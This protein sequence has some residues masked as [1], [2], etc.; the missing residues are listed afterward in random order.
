VEVAGGIG[1]DIVVEFGPEV[2]ITMVFDTAACTSRGDGGQEVLYPDWWGCRGW[3]P[4]KSQKL[5]YKIKLLQIVPIIALNSC[6]IISVIRLFYQI[7]I[8]IFYLTIK[9]LSETIIFNV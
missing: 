8:F 5:I 1:V 4:H 9:Y 2:V 3:S 7:V 6:F